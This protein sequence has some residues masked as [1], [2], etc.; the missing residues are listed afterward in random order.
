MEIANAIRVFAGGDH[1]FIQLDPQL[2]KK[3]KPEEET[4]MTSMIS[5]T[6]KESTESNLLDDLTPDD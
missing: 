3:E 6:S 4:K 2:P 1:S 5:E